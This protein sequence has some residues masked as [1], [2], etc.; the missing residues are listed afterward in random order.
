MKI[1]SI[2]P[3]VCAQIVI[4]NMEELKN[5]GNVFMKNFMLVD[6]VKIAI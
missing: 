6:F 3:K 2:M 4:I 5:H 1:K